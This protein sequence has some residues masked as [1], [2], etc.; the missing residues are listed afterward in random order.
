MV[1]R[2][3]KKATKQLGKDIAGGLNLLSAGFVR[4]IETTR[5]FVSAVKGNSNPLLTTVKQVRKQSKLKN[6]GA[7]VRTTAIAGSLL[8]P[9]K[10]ATGITRVLTS[11][12]LKAGA[13]KTSTA[14]FGVGAFATSKRV[15]KVA[16][17][18]TN[19]LA[20]VEKGA[21]TGVL[22]DQPKKVKEEIKKEGDSRIC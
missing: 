16:D 21:K 4:P 18:V 22:I 11:G 19:P 7:T 15:R 13:L 3:I 8:S 6:I 5:G 14:L 2:F 20:I 9:V 1:F 17:V 10:T 12:G